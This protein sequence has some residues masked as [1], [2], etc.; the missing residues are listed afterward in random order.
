MNELICFFNNRFMPLTEAGLPVNDI[1]VGR[2]YGIFDFLRVSSNIPLYRDDHLDR[3]FLSAKEMRLPVS[4]KKENLQDI[5]TQLL[6]QNNLLNSGIRIMLSGGVSTDG[7]S[8][9]KP[10]LV[11]VQ[12]P[13]SLPLNHIFQKGYT[14]ISYPYQR[15]IPHVKTTDYLMAI[16]LQPLVKEREAD[17]ILYHQN[18][19]VSECPRSNFFIVTKEKKIVTPGRNMLKGITRKQVLSLAVKNGMVVEERD[20]SL[21][22]IKL[23]KE[24]FITSS[25]KRI[26][27][28]AQVDDIIFE[29]CT[30]ESVTWQLFDLL[31][32]KEK[33]AICLPF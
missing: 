9:E 30:K 18:G 32:N 31:L 25:T 5:I 20:I 4:Y 13:I 16:W 2:G 14:L 17:D 12:Q 23:A 3:F 10:N 1:G 24:A 26:V 28:V 29:P 7:Y 33:E 11:I 22:D 8:I 15:Q 21:K 27:P 19:M 6:Q